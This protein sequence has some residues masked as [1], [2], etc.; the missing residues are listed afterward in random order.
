MQV[1]V[2]LVVL[3]NNGVDHRAAHV[4]RHGCSKVHQQP[5]LLARVVKRPPHLPLF[6]NEQTTDQLLDIRVTGRNLLQ[7]RV[8]GRET[9]RHR[10][11]VIAAQ[12]VKFCVDAPLVLMPQDAVDERAVRLVKLPQLHDLLA[13]LMWVGVQIL[14]GKRGCTS[15][16]LG[17]A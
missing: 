11:A 6:W 13:H 10:A 15:V 1:N 9:P 5:W 2:A 3:I 14:L 16:R 17:I 8:R 4:V 7:V 12:L